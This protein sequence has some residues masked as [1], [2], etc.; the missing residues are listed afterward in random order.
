VASHAMDIIR[1]SNCKSCHSL[2]TLK[3]VLQSVPAPMLD[4]IGAL[5][6]EA[7]IYDYLSAPDPQ[8]VLPSRLKKEYR[9]PSYA[10]LSDEE[11]H[12]LS[13]YLASLQVKDWYLDQTRKLEYEKLT[14]MEPQK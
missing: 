1:S 14:G 10:K 5:R 2:W 13:K 4:G 12:L 9:M 11:R 6:S 7:W 3:D 8:A